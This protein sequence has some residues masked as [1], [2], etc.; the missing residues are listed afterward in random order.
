MCLEAKTRKT[1]AKSLVRVGP[2]FYPRRY[3]LARTA[4]AFDMDLKHYIP[5]GEDTGRYN[6]ICVVKARGLI[7]RDGLSVGYILHT[8]ED[9]KKT[10]VW[11][12]GCENQFYC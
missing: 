12:L 10:I 6:L 8:R 7:E 3:V 4:S 9:G 5:P 11:R 2:I 1:V